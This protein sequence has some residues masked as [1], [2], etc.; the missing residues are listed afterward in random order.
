MKCQHWFRLFNVLR[1]NVFK[2]LYVCKSHVKYTDLYISQKENLSMLV[3]ADKGISMCNFQ[4][5]AHN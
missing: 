1:I 4:R 3:F 2:K 5:R